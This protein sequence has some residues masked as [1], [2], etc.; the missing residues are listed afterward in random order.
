MRRFFFEKHLLW[1]KKIK[2]KRIGTIFILVLVQIMNMDTTMNNGCTECSQ[3]H[4]NICSGRGGERIFIW[5]PYYYENDR[6]NC[7]LH[8]QSWTYRHAHRRS[9]AAQCLW[10]IVPIQIWWGGL[11]FPTIGKEGRCR[12][13]QQIIIILSMYSNFNITIY[14]TVKHNKLL[15]IS[16]INITCFGP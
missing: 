12:I 3:K 1:N 9:S 16:L 7:V 2:K 11:D 4:T 14:I 13:K 8:A 5:N 6:K 10:A 15:I